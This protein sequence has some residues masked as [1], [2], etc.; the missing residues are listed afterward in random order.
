MGINCASS[1]KPLEPS[2]ISFLKEEIL[3]VSSYT[4]TQL[5]WA[6]ENKQT[7]ALSYYIIKIV[8]KYEKQ[9]INSYKRNITLCL[10][11]LRNE[12]LT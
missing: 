4:A 2:D 7:F 5:S 10:K 1:K 11:I 3:K 9:Y 6:K 12:G 8:I